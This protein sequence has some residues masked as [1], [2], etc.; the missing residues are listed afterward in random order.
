MHLILKTFKN[1]TIEYKLNTLTQFCIAL[2]IAIS[3]LKNCVFYVKYIHIA[4][5]Q[6]PNIKQCLHCEVPSHF[7][8]YIDCM[9]FGMHNVSSVSIGLTSSRS[10]SIFI[11]SILVD[12]SFETLRSTLI[13]KPTTQ[14]LQRYQPP[15]HLQ[16]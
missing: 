7:Q 5:V 15:A 8:V 10:I 2:L 12:M 11:H 9:C 3:Q 16:I 4:S 1:T 14:S 13:I 6:L